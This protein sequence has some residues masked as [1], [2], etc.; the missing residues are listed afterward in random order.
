MLDTETWSLESNEGF[1][2]VN[3]HLWYKY[4]CIKCYDNNENMM[5]IMMKIETTYIAVLFSIVQNKLQ[6]E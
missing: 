1:R 6:F 4:Y 2:Q 5:M 3:R